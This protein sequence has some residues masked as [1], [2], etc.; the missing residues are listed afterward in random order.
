[1]IVTGGALPQCVQ[2]S[3]QFALQKEIS[4]ESGSP[5]VLSTNRKVLLQTLK[6]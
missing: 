5:S 6:R 1:M 3:I 4:P 2:R